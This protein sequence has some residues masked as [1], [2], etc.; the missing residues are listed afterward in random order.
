MSA[1][2]G[3]EKLSKDTEI[4]H[5]SGYFNV[6]ENKILKLKVILFLKIL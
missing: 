2:Y 5:N 4:I 3:G 1:I 6:K